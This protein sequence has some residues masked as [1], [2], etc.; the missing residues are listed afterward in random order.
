MQGLVILR[1]VRPL[2]PGALFEIA[3]DEG[4]QPYFP[5]FVNNDLPRDDAITQEIVGSTQGFAI[6]DEDG[7]IYKKFKV[8]A[9]AERA[10]ASAVPSFSVEL[11]IPEAE[12]EVD[13][14]DVDDEE[15]ATV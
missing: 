5:E 13:D 12:N 4:D 11:D 1:K 10:R 3:K 6:A 8:L 14:F 2:S 7:N 9:D 15:E